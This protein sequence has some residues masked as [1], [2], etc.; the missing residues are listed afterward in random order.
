MRIALTAL[1]LAA[2][3]LAACD[4]TTDPRF[5]PAEICVPGELVVETIEEGTSPST[6]RPT[7]SVVVNYT[8]TFVASRDT[9]DA[10]GRATFNLG[11]RSLITGFRQG[12]A[13]ATVGDSLQIVIPPSLGYGGR[14]YPPGRPTTIPA[15]ST[16]QFNLRVVDIVG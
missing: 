6:V 12:V 14:D 8:G 10:G 16:L 2:L 1:A 5:E 3:G 13:G 15:C 11:S 7:S 9:F 4:S